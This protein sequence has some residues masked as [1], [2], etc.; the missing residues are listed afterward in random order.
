MDCQDIGALLSATLD[1]ALSVDESRAVSAHLRSCPACARRLAL[2]SDTQQA[3]RSSVAEP[4]RPRYVRAGALA[5]ATV[6]AIA[7]LVVVMRS[8]ERSPHQLQNPDAAAD[9]GVIDPVFC[10]VEMSPCSGT[11]CAPLVPE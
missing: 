5:A 8:P 2:L 9:C 10:V 7:V 4:A 6:A 3:F 11:E 1:G